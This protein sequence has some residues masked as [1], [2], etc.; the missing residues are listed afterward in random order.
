MLR[1]LL[2]RGWFPSGPR[3]GFRVERAGRR[4]RQYEGEGGEGGEGGSGGG[5]GGEGGGGE[6]GG[7]GGGSGGGADD[8]KFSQKDVDGF[9]TKQKKAFQTKQRETLAELEKSREEQGLSVAH[10]KQLDG[11]IAELRTDLMSESDKSA[12]EKQRVAREHQTALDTVTGE[13]DAAI[14]R[15]ETSS[16]RTEMASACITHEVVNAEQ[17]MAIVGPKTSLVEEKDGE[18]KGTGVFNV[19]VTDMVKGEDE[20][21]AKKEFTVDEY[22]KHMKGM[23]EHENLFKQTRAGG[24]GFRSGTGGGGTKDTSGMTANEKINSGLHKGQASKARPR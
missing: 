15:Y 14:E 17:V 9:M 16:K 7:S 12:A 8:K 23:V 13:R 6:G 10:A 11:Q 22:L 3:F 1:E 24:T 20:K 21:F 5:G 4:F 18:G 19:V 2:R